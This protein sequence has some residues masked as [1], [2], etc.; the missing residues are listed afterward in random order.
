M[1]IGE[2]SY[3]GEIEAMRDADGTVR[4]FLPQRRYVNADNIPLINME[5][6]HSANSGYLATSGQAASMFSPHS[7]LRPLR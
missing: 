2:F 5:P 6:V 3:L 1:K 7:V 4:Q